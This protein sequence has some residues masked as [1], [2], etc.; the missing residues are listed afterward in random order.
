MIEFLLIVFY[1]GFGCYL[2]LLVTWIFYV[3]IMHLKMKLPTMS[4]VAKFNAYV[5]LFLLGY[6][7]DV[8]ANLIVSALAFQRFPKDWLLTG[9]LKE[10]VASGDKRRAKWA[11]YICRDLLNPFDPSLK[12][13]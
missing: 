4:P 12:H 9:T 2:A 10:W 1:W 11:G 5:A 7:L 3:A 8:L 6:P 13:C